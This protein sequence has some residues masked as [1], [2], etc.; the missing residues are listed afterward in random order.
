MAANDPKKKAAAIGSAMVHARKGMIYLVSE[1]GGQK[2]GAGKDLKTLLV[3]FQKLEMAFDKITRD[4]PDSGK[5]VQTYI[6]AVKGD[7]DGIR[8][9]MMDIVV[10]VGDRTPKGKEISKILV[11]FQKVEAN[12]KTAAKSL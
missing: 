9:A 1:I 7:M 2:G 6:D 10:E 11:D 12:F 4:M 8:K 5:D 3:D